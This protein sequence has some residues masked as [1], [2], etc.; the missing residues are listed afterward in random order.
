MLL[1]FTIHIVISDIQ[2][3]KMNGIELT[4]E[5]YKINPS[6]KVIILS[7]FYDSN[8]LVE[9]VNIGIKQFIKKPIDFQELIKALM[10]TSK[11]LDTNLA[12]DNIVFF[13][14]TT[15]YN[16]QVSAL[17]KENENIYL[18][19]YEIIFL[20][21]LLNTV[22]KIYTNDSIVENF[23]KHNEILD[24]QNIRKLVSKLRKKVPKEAIESIYGIIYKIIPYHKS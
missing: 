1:K 4:K 8:Y 21:F 18:T 9:L 3:P 15:S 20:D 6:Q 17:E 13:N 14:E 7:A 16:K 23:K 22:G 2:M 5:L 24:M 19:K 10:Q 11:K 12:L